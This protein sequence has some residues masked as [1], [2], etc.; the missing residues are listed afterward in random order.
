MDMIFV[1]LSRENAP[2]NPPIDS[3]GQE[4]T[5]IVILGKTQFFPSLLSKSRVCIS[6]TGMTVT[7][8]ILS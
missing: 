5:D 1:D 6:T 4:I 7:S 8:S 3:N 2:N